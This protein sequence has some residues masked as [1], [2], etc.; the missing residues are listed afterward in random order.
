MDPG[1]IGPRGTS[2]GGVPPEQNMLKVR[3][4][5]FDGELR[6]WELQLEEPLHSP[7]QQVGVSL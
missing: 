2:P 3:V 5:E 4:G 1:L 7:R 6:S